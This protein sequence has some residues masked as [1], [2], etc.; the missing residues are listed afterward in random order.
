[1]KRAI[2]VA[3]A[4]GAVVASAAPL[5]VASPETPQAAAERAPFGASVVAMQAAARLAQRAG[6]QAR[7]EKQR[8]RCDDLRGAEHDRCLIDAHASRGLALLEAAAPYQ[9]G[10]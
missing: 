6:I 1:M 5:G 8:A 4:I 3:L 9:S 7:Y 10:R 2:F